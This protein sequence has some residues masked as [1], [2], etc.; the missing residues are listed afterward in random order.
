ME[1]HVIREADAPRILDWMLHRGGIAVWRSVNLSNPSG[2]W[3]TPATTDGAPTR[4]PTW[5]ADQ[6]PARVIDD[7]ND[8]EVMVPREVRRFHVGVRRGTSNPYMLKLTDGSTRRLRAA[9]AKAGD[10]AWYEFDYY[11]QEAVIFV[12]AGHSKPLLTWDLERTRTGT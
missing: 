4:R 3:T 5:E 11:T 8:V 2:Q 10:G 12:P 7:P 1:K 6:K 9:V